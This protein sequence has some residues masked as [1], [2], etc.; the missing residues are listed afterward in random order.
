MIDIQSISYN[1]MEFLKIIK[2]KKDYRKKYKIINI[3]NIK[4]Q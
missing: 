3:K 2:E 1:Y 4:L